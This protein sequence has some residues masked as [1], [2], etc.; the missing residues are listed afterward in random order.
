M[1]LIRVVSNPLVG[2]RAPRRFSLRGLCCTVRFVAQEVRRSSPLHTVGG[3]TMTTSR[4][5]IDSLYRGK[6][7][8]RVGLVGHPWP[9]PTRSTG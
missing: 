8:E 3:G 7:A 1:F 6:R 2:N 5:V 4:Q 9:W